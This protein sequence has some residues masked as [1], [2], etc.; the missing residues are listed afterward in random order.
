LLHYRRVCGTGCTLCTRYEILVMH[1]SLCEVLRISLCENNL[2]IDVW[3]QA[4]DE[5]TQ[6]LACRKRTELLFSRT[7]DS[8]QRVT[9]VVQRCDVRRIEVRRRCTAH[10][11]RL[12]FH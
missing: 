6:R 12:R 7:E 9:L 10:A 11:L 4:A 8:S 3:S 2:S 1:S 5:L